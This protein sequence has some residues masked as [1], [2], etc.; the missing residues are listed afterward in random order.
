MAAQPK[1]T[2]LIPGIGSVSQDPFVYEVAARQLDRQFDRYRDVLTLSI[3]L[4]AAALA[5]IAFL[6]VDKASNLDCIYVIGL[7]IGG[8]VA[9]AVFFRSDASESPDGKAIALSYDSDPDLARATATGSVLLTIE[10]N[11]RPLNLKIGAARLR[12]HASRRR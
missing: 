4:L 7:A 10:L 11:S 3:G 1:S 6:L 2:V 12:G 9:L 8:L 5:A